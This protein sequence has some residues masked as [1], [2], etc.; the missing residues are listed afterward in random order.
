MTKAN[1]P[2]SFEAHYKKFSPLKVSL[3]CLFVIT[4]YLQLGGRIGFLGTIRFE[5]LL[6]VLLIILSLLESGSDRRTNESPLT[7]LVCAYWFTLLLGVLFSVDI[8][9]S[10]NIF[11]NRIVK[12][13]ML[14][15]FITSFISSPKAL[16]WFLIAFILSCAKIASEGFLGWFS[17]SL[18]WENQGIMRLH[19]STGNYVHP[20]SFSGF[21]VGLLPFL[22]FLFP[23]SN[24]IQKCFLVAVVIFTFVIIIYTGSRTGYVG[25]LAVLGYIFY[26]SNNKKTFVKII[27]LVAVIGLPQVPSQ[28]FERFTS[29]YTGHEKE[30][31]STEK[32]LEIL[33]DASQVFI[34]YPL[35][36]GI[37][38]FP[39]VRDQ[40]FGR[41]QDTHN[42]YFEVLTNIGIHGFIIFLILVYKILNLLK[43][44]RGSLLKQIESVKVSLQNLA[45]KDLNQDEVSNA[46][47]SDL[48][49]LLAV[50][51][52]TSAFLIA[53]LT[54][55]FFGMDLY[56][57]YWWLGIGLTIM[58]YRL[59]KIAQKRTEE[60]LT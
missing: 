8:S 12:F 10:W 22:Y 58:L 5:F 47:L 45:G 27:L 51:S 38:S 28:Y 26:I 2:Y 55:G 42:L 31:K 13:S 14:A 37:G 1:K 49:L 16:K 19:G 33:A 43:K 34:K 59:N 6:G 46:H 7:P 15:L 24:K 50:A 29:I 20:N 9:H 3:T 17:G 21:A 32:R 30:G 36:V 53:R 41:K 18:M 57:I 56:E 60:I 11:F 44:I 40:L 52:A 23:V 35:G 39:Q 25:S 4:W 48:Q 54:L